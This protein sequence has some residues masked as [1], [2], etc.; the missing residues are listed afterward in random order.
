MSRKRKA[1]EPRAAVFASPQRLSEIIRSVVANQPGTAEDKQQFVRQAV[2]FV[3]SKQVKRRKLCKDA[4]PTN[5]WRV[6]RVRKRAQKIVVHP[7]TVKPFL[8]PKD[9]EERR[10]VETTKMQK[11][12]TEGTAGLEIPKKRLKQAKQE[13]TEAARWMQTLEPAVIAWLKSNP[14]AEF[15]LEDG[16]VALKPLQTAPNTQMIKMSH[17]EF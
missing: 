10:I 6:R 1:P 7:E 17:T 15:L 3:Q 12:A 14:K 5:T 16:K 11:D 8:K 4:L 2:Q 13:K 9:D